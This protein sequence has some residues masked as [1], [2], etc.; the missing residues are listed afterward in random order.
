MHYQNLLENIQGGN[1]LLLYTFVNKQ[2]LF[3][4]LLISAVVKVNYMQIFG[5]PQKSWPLFY[6]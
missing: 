2:T 6:N 3:Y 1:V 4:I 5:A